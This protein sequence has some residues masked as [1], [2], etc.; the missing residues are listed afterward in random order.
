MIWGY[1]CSVFMDVF[2]R[3]S[4]SSAR[5]DGL[6]LSIVGEEPSGAQSQ[7]RETVFLC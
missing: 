7:S 5:N 4:T 1:G 2:V 3:Q 6:T